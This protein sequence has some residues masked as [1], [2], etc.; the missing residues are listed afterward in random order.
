[1]EIARGCAWDRRVSSG[2]ALRSCFFCGIAQPPVHKRGK[3]PAQVAREIGDQSLQYKTTRLH[4]YDSEISNASGGALAS[5]LRAHRRH[6]R[7]SMDVRASVG[8]EFLAQMAQA[9]CIAVQV[10]IVGLTTSQLRRLNKGA[11]TIQNLT[12]MRA[13]FEL[14]LASDS[15]LIGFPGATA[16]EITETCDNIRRFAV[17]YEPLRPACFVLD[18]FSP[19]YEKPSRFGIKN[20]C[21]AAPLRAVLP[22]A[23]E[24]AVR[25]PWSE[26]DCELPAADW[27]PVMDACDEWRQLHRR[28]REECSVAGSARPL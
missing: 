20:V 5:E 7:F 16:D 23:I 12:A 19:A 15:P 24:Q 11:T 8:H 21:H 25:L 4:F 6:Y 22:P 26:F 9:G 2:D 28:L 3:R 27:K 18:A 14:G 17:A 1:V 10:G 13:A